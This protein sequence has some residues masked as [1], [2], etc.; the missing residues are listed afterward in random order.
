MVKGIIWIVQRY[1]TVGI[2]HDVGG[3]GRDPCD[4]GIREIGKECV[5]WRIS[6]V[7]DSKRIT[8]GDS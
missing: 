3:E 6:T 8:L 5:E 2:G 7:E 4:L 1:S